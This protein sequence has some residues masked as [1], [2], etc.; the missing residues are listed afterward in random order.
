M[1]PY[2]RMLEM[3]EERGE[4]R[5][6]YQMTAAVVLS[7]SPLTIM[8]N[9]TQI[10]VNVHCNPALLL[11][12]KPETVQTEEIALKKC[13]TDF[14]SAFRLTVNDRVLVQQVGDQFYVICKVVDV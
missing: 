7:V 2:S 4:T 3:M 1:N 13:L 5:N 6:G 11:G 14:Y 9:E 8:V 12:L 10:S